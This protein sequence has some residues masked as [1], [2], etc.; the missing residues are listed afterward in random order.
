MLD[1]FTT[2]QILAALLGLYF[3][4]AGIGLL[5]DPDSIAEM[6]TEMVGQPMLG[7]LGAIVAFSI[8]GAVV[9]VHNNWD[10][11]LA[12]IVSLIGWISL[13]EGVLMLALRKRFLGWFSGMAQSPGIVKGFGVATPVAGLAL[14]VAA[15]AS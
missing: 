13:A 15:F 5:S 7:F 14:I 3:L 6:M 4:A 8:G 10:S 12:G 9:A 11:L 2:T 1:S